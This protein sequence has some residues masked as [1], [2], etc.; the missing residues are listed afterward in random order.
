MSLEITI[1][2]IAK[3]VVTPRVT[4]RE[5]VPNF[6]RQ[7]GI[8]RPPQPVHFLVAHTPNQMRGQ[9]VDAGGRTPIHI[10][11][12]VSAPSSLSRSLSYAL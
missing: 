5:S 10:H 9:G 4:Q 8:E 3:R 7:K 6:P 2:W 12:R 1:V 11:T